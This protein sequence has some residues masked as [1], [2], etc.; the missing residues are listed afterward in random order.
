MRLTFRRPYQVPCQYLRATLDGVMKGRV[1]GGALDLGV[2]VSLHAQHEDDALQVLI[3]H[4]K[5]EEVLAS[6]VHLCETH[7]TCMQYISGNMFYVKETHSTC[8]QYISGNMFYVKGNTFYMH[9]VHLRKHV[10]CQG[11]TFYMHAVG[12]ETCCTSRSTCMQYDGETHSTCIRTSAT[13]LSLSLSLSLP[14]L[15]LLRYSLPMFCY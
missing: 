11:N 4:G 7:S 6:G 14:L 12:Q 10:L 13:L 2:D 8:M 5:M 15:L 1:H 3:Q 9:A